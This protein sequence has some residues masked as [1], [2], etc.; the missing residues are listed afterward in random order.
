MSISKN[1]FAAACY[2]LPPIT[3][4]IL[5]TADATVISEILWSMEPWRTLGSTQIGLEKYL[6]GSDPALRRYGMWRAGEI[7]GVVCVRSPWLRGPY[8]ELL[9][10]FPSAQGGGIGRKILR[11]LEEESRAAANNIW[12]VASEGN[13]H[14]RKFYRASHFVEVATLPNLVAKGYNEIL[15]RKTINP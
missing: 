1:L 13:E 5:K 11:W 2:R 4:H 7:I 9:A 12:T 14:A 3:L 15:L 6:C 10:V 8:L